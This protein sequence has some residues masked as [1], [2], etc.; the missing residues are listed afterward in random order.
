MKNIS[1]M[2][3]DCEANTITAFLIFMDGIVWL[4]MVVMQIKLRWRQE[5]LLLSPCLVI[6]Y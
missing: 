2:T 1:L 3:D 4:D 6:L 5:N